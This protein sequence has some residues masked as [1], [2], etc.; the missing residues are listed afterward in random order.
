MSTGLA[1]IPAIEAACQAHRD[2]NTALRVEPP[3]V[4]LWMNKADGSPGLVK[5]GEARDSVNG[6]FPFKKNTFGTAGT[7]RLRLD[8][9][10]AKWLIS[11]PNDPAAKKNVVITVDHMGGA[12]RWSGLLKNWTITKDAQGIRYLDV[13]FIDD[14]QFLQFMLGPPNPL[15]P[16]PVFQFPRVLPMYG[17]AKWA[18]SMMILINLIRIEGNLWTLP[19]DP[20]AVGSWGSLFNWSSW[21]VLIKAKAFDFDDSSTW[22]LLATRMNRMD[23]IIADALDDAQLVMR[24]RR[25][26]TD[27]GETSDIPGVPNVANGALVLEVVDE[28]GYYS[29]DGTSLGGGLFGGFVRSVINFASGFDEDIA[30]TVGNSSTIYPDAFYQNGYRGSPPSHPWVVVRDSI[31]TSIQTSKLTWS[32]ATATSVIVGGD[33]PLA[34][35]L[36]QLFIES[37]GSLIGYFLL[38]GFSGLGSIASTVIM[39]FLVG[40]I[41]AWLQWK[42][43]GRAHELG[44]VHL[45]EIFGQGA[46]NNAWS[47]S[48]IAAIRSAFMASKSETAHQFTMGSGGPFLPALDFHIGSRI[49]STCEIEDVPALSS[50]IF[51]D[52]VE[53]MTLGW[54]Y[55]NDTPHEYEVTVGQ[56]KAAMS[57]SERTARAL[58]KAMTTISN[59]GVHLTS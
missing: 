15:L 39:P 24:Y 36:A 22:A 47:L 56:A 32:P 29:A 49:G 27:D 33:N 21:Q 17:P 35:Q 18:I 26:I 28:S 38:G 50:L 14:L 6:K 37:I 13:T 12:F 16:I 48:A 55:A 40:T 43:I 58:S 46:E 31:Y 51:V 34:D 54:D 23:S 52:Q 45:W 20:F 4:R 10:L 44:W 7:L 41:A 5:R 25:I 9:Y 8:H 2:F 3:R 30:T 42:N 57:Q 19:D 53:E 1:D 59:I 11:I